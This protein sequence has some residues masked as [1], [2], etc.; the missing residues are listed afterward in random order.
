MIS[1]ENSSS[2]SSLSIAIIWSSTSPRSQ[3]ISSFR[4]FFL[5]TVRIREKWIKTPSLV[6]DQ[7]SI[8]MRSWHVHINLVVPMQTSSLL[9]LPTVFLS[10]L[11]YPYS[12]SA[13]ILEISHF[14]SVWQ[15]HLLFDR[16]QRLV[17][18]EDWRN[19]RVI[20]DI[21]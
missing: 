20:I 11:Q 13:Q 2:S 7:R 18:K 19:V 16:L 3:G 1:V 14:L 4:S 10:S 17:L 8:K 21:R 12:T 9:S 5:Q 6:K 15:Q